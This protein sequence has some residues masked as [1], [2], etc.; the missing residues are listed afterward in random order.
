VNNIYLDFH[1]TENIRYLL[2]A[3]Q[4]DR[5]F[6]Q[7]HVF[8]TVSNGKLTSVA[9]IGSHCSAFNVVD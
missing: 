3:H 6:S 8:S 4:I 7:L 5:I 2:E 1:I 9:I